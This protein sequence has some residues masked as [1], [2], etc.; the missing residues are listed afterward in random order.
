MKCKLLEF[1][2]L[3]AFLAAIA[4]TQSCSNG[5]GS[6]KG[7]Y[8]PLTPVEFYASATYED[9][10]YAPKG[11]FDGNPATMW[12]SP[13]PDGTLG[14]LAVKLQEP[15]KLRR[16]TVQIKADTTSQ[17]PTQIDVLGSQDN[18]NWI[19]VQAV[20]GLRW[21]AGETKQIDLNGSTRYQFYKFDFTG[22]RQYQTHWISILDMQL[23]G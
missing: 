7:P 13:P 22:N 14:W 23:F 15:D 12:H 5:D 8:K 19:L 6:A 21:T 3:G 4:L 20:N 1:S 2:R 18:V 10:Q 16:V 9:P 17:A 11:A